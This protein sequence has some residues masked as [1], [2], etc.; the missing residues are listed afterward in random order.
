MKTIRFLSF[1]LYLAFFF[2][3]FVACSDDDPEETVRPPYMYAEQTLF[4]IDAKAQTITVTL[5]TNL[6]KVEV[7]VPEEY[8]WIQLVN[9]TDGENA[10]A[11]LF[12]IADN[13]ESELRQGGIAIKDPENRIAAITISVRQSASE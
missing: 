10:K 7:W 12:Q 2:C 3:S 5:N 1:C 9:I 11:C 4:E 8:P 13:T 6:S